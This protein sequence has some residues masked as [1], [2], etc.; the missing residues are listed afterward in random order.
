MFALSYI[1]P[2]VFVGVFTQQRE[3]I[4]LSVWG[5]QVF[6][7]MIIPLAFQYTFVDAL[8]ALGQV[9][10]SVTFSLLRK[11]LFLVMT[12]ALPAFF[13]ARAAFYAEPICDGAA[14]VISSTGFLLLFG[15]LMRRREQMPDGEALYQ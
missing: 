15:G 10:R 2:R 12:L 11:S 1:A 13:G 7:M 14:A 9:K 8:T 3:V 5:I 4:D 6:T